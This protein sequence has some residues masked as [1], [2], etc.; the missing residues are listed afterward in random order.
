M[1]KLTKCK[2]TQNK[3]QTNK[4]KKNPDLPEVKM[5]YTDTVLE[6]CLKMLQANLACNSEK[7]QAR[8]KSYRPKLFRAFKW[9]IKPGHISTYFHQLQVTTSSQWTSHASRK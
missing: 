4:I 2:N 8:V 5:A 3:I 7:L 6:I 9:E 1:Q